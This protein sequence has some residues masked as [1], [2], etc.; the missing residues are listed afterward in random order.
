MVAKNIVVICRKS[1]AKAFFFG[2]KVQ[3]NKCN[4]KVKQEEKTWFRQTIP[5]FSSNGTLAQRLLA[6]VGRGVVGNRA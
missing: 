1:N 2:T 3:H 4:I 5:Y 6:S